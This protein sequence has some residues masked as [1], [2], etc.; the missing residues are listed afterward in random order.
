MS[1]LT[2]SVLVVAV[3]FGGAV[4]HAQ[5]QVPPPPTGDAKRGQELFD[6]TYK[7]YACHGYDG[8]TGNP[9]LVPMSRTQEAFIAYVRKP[10]TAGM[11]KFVDPPEK[12]LVDVY[13]YIRSIPVAA[14]STDSIPLLKGII[15]RRGKTN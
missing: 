4:P 10:A 15:D 11:P 8:Q 14:P 5:T 6:K 3:M 2:I 1:R 13:A 7:C 12:D 9:R